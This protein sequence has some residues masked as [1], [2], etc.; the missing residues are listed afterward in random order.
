MS[1][2]GEK[3][4]TH[5]VALLCSLLLLALVIVVNAAPTVTPISAGTVTSPAPDDGDTHVTLA[6]APHFTDYSNS[7]ISELAEKFL[8]PPDASAASIPDRAKT[9]PAVPATLLMVLT[10]F[11]CVSL[12]RDR[13]VWIA[14]LA[15]LLW[16][17]QVG[18]QNLPKLAQRFAHTNH[19][20][21]QAS[22]SKLARSR[23]LETFGRSRADIEGTRYVALL[24]YLA[25]IPNGSTVSL[26]ENTSRKNLD[27]SGPVQYALTHLPVFAAR[28]IRALAAEAAQFTYFSPAFIFQNLA[29]GPPEFQ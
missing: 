12:V 10:G 19:N 3:L 14:A 9:L 15:G 28:P 23:Q 22:S 16:A 17:G 7:T 21:R 26:F 6:E 4:L 27:I 13:R 5:S 29:R 20:A 11:A 25:G 24:H 8:A 18:V 1:R 2:S